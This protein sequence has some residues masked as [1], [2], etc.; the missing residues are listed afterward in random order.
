MSDFLI[1]W[2]EL[3]AWLFFVTILVYRYWRLT[4]PAT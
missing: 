2:T 3:M 4:E 1:A